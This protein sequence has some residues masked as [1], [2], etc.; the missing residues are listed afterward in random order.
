MAHFAVTDVAGGRIRAH[1]QFAREALGLAGA[2]AHPFAVWTG[3]WRVES[4]GE[5]TFPMR[6]TARRSGLARVSS[7]SC[8]AA[9]AAVGSP[10][11]YGNRPLRK[12]ALAA[13][14]E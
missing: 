3:D 1:E 13:Q 7:I 10:A 9:M 5:E 12:A 2:R 14:G 11:W 6:L 8:Q 4:V